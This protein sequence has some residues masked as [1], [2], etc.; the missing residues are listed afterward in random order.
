MF[1]FMQPAPRQTLS[2]NTNRWTAVKAKHVVT[3]FGLCGLFSLP[4]SLSAQSTPTL[5]KAHEAFNSG[6]YE[7]ALNYYERATGIRSRAVQGYLGLAGVYLQTGEYSKAEKACRDALEI[8]SRH[9]EALTLLGEVLQGTGRYQEALEHYHRALAQNPTHL[10]ARLNLGKLQ[11]DL[12]DRVASRQTLQYFIDYYRSRTSLSAE[13]IAYVAEACIYLER[14][15]DAN[16]LFYD[17]TK[18]DP[19]LWQ[20]YIPWGNLFLSKYNEFDALGVFEDALAVNPRAAEAHLGRAKA[21]ISE[22]YDQAMSVLD[23]ALEINPNL[24]EAHNLRAETAI[25]ASEFDE[26][27]EHL[28]T[29]LEVNPNALAARALKAL[30][31]YLRDEEQNFAAEEQKILAVNPH[32]GELYFQIADILARRYLFQE[33][34]EF[35]RKALDLNPEHWLARAGLGTSLSRLGEEEAARQEL[36]RAFAKDPYNKYVGNLLTLFDEY[37]D[38][39]THR[40]DGYVLRIHK[41]EADVLAPYAVALIESSLAYLRQRYPSDFSQPV[42]IEIFPE[43]DDF[44]VRCFGLPGAQAFLGICFGNVIAMDSPQA[45]SKG[46]FAWGETLWHELVHVTHLRLTENRIPRWLAEGIA[47]YETAS[48]HPYWHMNLDLP[49]VLTFLNDNL[50]ALKEL[51]SGFSRPRN[52]G[53]VSLS[54]F[55]ASKV[56]EFIEETHGHKKLLELFPEFRAG[57]ETPEV[58]EKVFGQEIDAFDADFRAFLRAQ[59]R[60]DELTFNYDPREMADNRDA[61]ERLRNKVEENPNDP[62]LNFHV[63]L[64]YKRQGAYDEAVEHLTKSTELFPRFVQKENPYKALA[65][66]HS[67]QGNRQAAIDV[68]KALT[69]LNGK[70]LESLKLLAHWSAEVQGYPEAIEALRKAVYISPFDADIHKQLG[71]AYLAAKQ[72]DEA[73]REFQMRVLTESH[74]MAG[75]QCDLAY[76]YLMAGNKTD[77]KE[78]ALTAL[79]IAPSYDRAQEILLQCVE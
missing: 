61:G 41:K 77:A 58:I 54:Y 78:A 10:P 45:R 67:E 73:V 56:V 18:A 16:N 3:I 57:K 40:G 44:A 23:Q 4:I 55:Q 8:S 38:Y 39:S 5:K 31:H 66:I 32:Y 35:Y 34:V 72:Y 59:Y 2:L 15:R 19:N 13:E 63:G 36:E 14:V 27:L 22:N 71:D 9:P 79:E 24:V 47:V 76:A 49:F 1:G 46:D 50:L 17:A 12:G 37:P 28:Q 60:L 53:Q 65:E 68:L 74:D 48:Q 25:V 29:A 7:T 64:F 11:H 52:P 30:C 51:D 43:H 33:S 26:A 42:T 21:L 70:D 62:I 69:A 20:A 6:E 75:A